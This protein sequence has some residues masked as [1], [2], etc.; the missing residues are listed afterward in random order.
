M[1]IAS[2]EAGLSFFA[3]HGLVQDRRLAGLI[4]RRRRFNL[5]HLDDIGRQRSCLS[6]NLFGSGIFAGCR[7]R[8]R[9]SEREG[10]GYS[11]R[12]I[13]HHNSKI[14]ILLLQLLCDCCVDTICLVTSPSAMVSKRDFRRVLRNLVLLKAPKASW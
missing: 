2:T 13:L 8:E 4:V 12:F 11:L 14:V 5:A 9:Q 6:R 7:E 3:R 1:P 10:T